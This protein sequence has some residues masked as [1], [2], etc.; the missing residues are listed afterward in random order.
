MSQAFAYLYAFLR[1]KATEISSPS[2]PRDWLAGAPCRIIYD[3]QYI[4]YEIGIF[5]LALHAR[6]SGTSSL[7][8]C[9]PS[10]NAAFR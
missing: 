8:P 9:L 7:H 4:N 10:T 1:G 5:M 2:C 6:W 3:L